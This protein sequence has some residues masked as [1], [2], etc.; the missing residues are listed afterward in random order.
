[1]R[2]RQEGST[3][4][5]AI[6]DERASA[7]PEGAKQPKAVLL[8]PSLSAIL[9]VPAINRG[10]SCKNVPGS[11]HGEGCEPV[12]RGRLIASQSE[13]SA[14]ARSPKGQNSPKLFCSI[15]LVDVAIPPTFVPPAAEHICRQSFSRPH[16]KH[17]R[18]NTQP[19]SRQEPG[20][21]VQVCSQINQK[22]QR[23][24]AAKKG[25][26]SRNCSFSLPAHLVM[27]ITVVVI[28]IP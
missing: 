3:D 12:K 21:T 27:L 8:N 20:A 19:D 7:K 13:T 10:K 22:R 4:C 17:P 2:T 25:K 24:G 11:K 16:T 26:M 23:G 6:R 1:M 28:I 14:P 5:I 18:R 15:P 9:K